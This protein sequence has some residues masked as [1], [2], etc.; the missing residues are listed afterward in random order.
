MQAPWS[1]GYNQ[2]KDEYL[3]KIDQQIWAGVLQQYTTIEQTQQLYDKS[4]HGFLACQFL[5][6][7]SNELICSMV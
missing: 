2:F 4:I 5:P 1:D 6:L 7:G 3:V